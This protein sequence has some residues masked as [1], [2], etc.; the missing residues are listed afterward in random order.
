VRAFSVHPGKIYTP[1]QGHL[2][3]QEMVDNGWLDEDGTVIDPTFK[4][5]APQ[6]WAATSPRLADVGGLYCEVA[7]Q[8]DT[9]EIG[10][11]VRVYAVDPDSAA[12]LWTLS[13]ELTSVHS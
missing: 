8:N 4:G 9:E 7:E 11:G 1:L 2:R 3:R 10:H 6:V 12:R 5:A 13:E